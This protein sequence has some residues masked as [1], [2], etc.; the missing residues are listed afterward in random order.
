MLCGYLL[1]FLSRN[2]N[3][4]GSSTSLY[5]QYLI[6]KEKL[7]GQPVGF[8]W[9]NHL[10]QVGETSWDNFEMGKKVKMVEKSVPCSSKELYNTDEAHPSHPLIRH[11]HLQKFCYLS[12]WFYFFLG[13][14]MEFRFPSRFCRQVIK[15]TNSLN[16]VTIPQYCNEWHRK[17]ITDKK[18]QSVKMKR[19]E[20]VKKLEISFAVH[21]NECVR[22]CA[23]TRTHTHQHI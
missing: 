12:L 19:V 5:Y 20:K 6:K 17:L 13:N 15:Y 21:R 14:K 1:M 7:C 3:S 16:M 2:T 9:N 11:Y 10:D 22:V 23:Y 8:M 18:E 4:E